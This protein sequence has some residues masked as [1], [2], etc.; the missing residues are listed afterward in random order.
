M[1]L[2]NTI[3]GCGSLGSPLIGQ[4]FRTSAQVQG[5]LDQLKTLG[6]DRLDTAARYSPGNPGGSEKLIGEVRAASQGFTIDTKINIPDAAIADGAGSLTAAAIANS[7]DMSFDRLKV[8]KVHILHFHRSDPITPVAEQAAEIQKQYLAGR[9][10]K[11]GVSNFSTEEV[12]ELI[13]VCE[14]NGY[15]KPSVF[16]G[17]YNLIDRQMEESLFPLLR[18]HDIV[19]NAYSPL[20]SGFLTGRATRGDVEGTRFSPNNQISSVLNSMYD[21]PHIH[22][23][24]TGLLDTLEPLQISGSEACLRWIYHHS[25]LQEGDGVILGASKLL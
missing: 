15:I 17:R 3:F 9:F 22:T 25:V 11:F 7:I 19:F 14:E 5:L 6:I 23:A 16:Q 24:M 20:A 21:K 4:N 12:A 13:A 8:D 2:P 10:E 18:R 1:S